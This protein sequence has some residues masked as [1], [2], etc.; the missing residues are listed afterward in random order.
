MGDIAIRAEGL[1][2]LYRIG[3]QEKYKTFR[4]SL[5]SAVA[6]PFKR[7]YGLLRGNGYSAANLTRR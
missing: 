1:S 7:T 4:D 6:A 5:T 2:K 3:K